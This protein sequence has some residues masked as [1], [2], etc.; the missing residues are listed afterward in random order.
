MSKGRPT[1]KI[2]KNKHENVLY[3]SNSFLKKKK[4]KK[5]RQNVNQLEFIFYTD[6]CIIVFITR[7]MLRQLRNVKN[8]NLYYRM[9]T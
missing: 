1:E 3:L 9:K 7:R 5:N 6:T 8:S 4:K 2:H